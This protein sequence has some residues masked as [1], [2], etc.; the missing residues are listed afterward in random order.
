MIATSIAVSLAPA[1]IAGLGAVAVVALILLLVMK[2]L[3]TA[4][5]DSGRARPRLKFLVGSLNGAIIPLLLVFVVIVAVK[6]WQ[7][8]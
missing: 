6:V 8:L 3:T 4:E 1:V 5:L 7:V 2:E